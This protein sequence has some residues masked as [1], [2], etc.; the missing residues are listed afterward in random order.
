[1]SYIADSVNPALMNKEGASPSQEKEKEKSQESKR[2]EKPPIGVTMRL[3]D[4]LD[5]CRNC[6][7]N[8]VEAF[9]SK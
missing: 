7:K 5:Y 9:Y 4:Y 2:D 3:L 6:I 1:M 8:I